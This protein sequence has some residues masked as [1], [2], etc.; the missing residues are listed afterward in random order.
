MKTQN[1]E[2]LLCRYLGSISVVWMYSE[3]ILSKPKK[4]EN[5]VFFSVPSST[6][7][8]RQF[9]FT[10]FRIWE[11]QEAGSKPVNPAQ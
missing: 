4:I 9:N 11:E 1:L 8:D 7:F 3:A 6:T 2:L 10:I 5:G